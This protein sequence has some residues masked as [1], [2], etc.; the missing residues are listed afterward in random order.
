MYMSTFNDVQVA[1]LV[2]AGRRRGVAEVVNRACPRQGPCAN[3]VQ[4][5]ERSRSGTGQALELSSIGSS[6]DAH[7]DERGV[8]CIWQTVESTDED[9]TMILHLYFPTLQRLPILPCIRRVTLR[10]R[11]QP[12]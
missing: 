11:R 12:E 1:E 10:P 4:A 3:Q 6:T 9:D 2:R 5:G 7:L 8:M